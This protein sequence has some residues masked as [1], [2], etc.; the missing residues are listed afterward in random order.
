VLL[1]V[2]E[3]GERNVAQLRGDRSAF[4]ECH[5][6]TLLLGECKLPGIG[7]TVRCHC[8]ERFLDVMALKADQHCSTSLA[9][10]V[11]AVNLFLLVVDEG[12]GREEF[13]AI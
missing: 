2:D 10:A 12:E 1:S 7:A 4:L 6:P 3:K 9:A 8:Q 13:L 5:Q 11:W